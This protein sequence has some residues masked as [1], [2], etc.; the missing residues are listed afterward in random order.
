MNE[1]QQIEQYLN[2]TLAP[3]EQV[4]MEARLLLEPALR[5]KVLWQQRSHELIRAYSRK[6]IRLEIEKAHERLFSESRFSA[7]RRHIKHIFR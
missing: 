7:F 5:D 3:E 4:L 6:Q 2:R 1:V